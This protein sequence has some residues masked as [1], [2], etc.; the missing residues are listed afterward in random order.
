[1]HGYGSTGAR[2]GVLVLFTNFW[3]TLKKILYLGSADVTLILKKISL[4]S[5]LENNHRNKVFLDRTG[6]IVSGRTPS[7]YSN[8]VLIITLV[9]QYTSY[10]RGVLVHYCHDTISLLVRLYV[11]QRHV[12]T[13]V[14]IRWLLI[15]LAYQ[16]ACFYSGVLVVCTIP[17]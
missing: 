16:Y 6:V 12:S 3:P 4:L 13:K 8:S 2:V 17:F 10:Y 7:G 1:M 5:L 15:T 11:L 9:Y 14:S